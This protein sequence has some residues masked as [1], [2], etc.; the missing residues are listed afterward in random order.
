MHVPRKFCLSSSTVSPAA[1]LVSSAGLTVR[2]DVDNE[3]GVTESESDEEN[4]EE[5]RSD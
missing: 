5:D 4:G 1:P 2:D 3:E